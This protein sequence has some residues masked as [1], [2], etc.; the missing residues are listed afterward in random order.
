MSALRF[1]VVMFGA[2]D[3]YEVPL[4]LDE[5]GQLN[6]LITDFYTPDWLTRVL[7]SRHHPRLSSRKT[8]SVWPI[9]LLSK[10]VRSGKLGRLVVNDLFGFIGG[11]ITYLGPNRAIV[12]SY[13][14]EGFVAFYRLIGCKPNALIC[15]Q[16]H[17][18]PWFINRII[19]DDAEAF[20]RIRRVAFLKDIEDSYSRTEINAYVDALNA[21]DSILCASSVTARS[22]VHPRAQSNPCVVIPYGSRHAGYPLNASRHW[23][24]RDK[25]KILTVS[26]VMQ[27]KGLHWAFE[28]M[29]RLAP[30]LQEHFE[31]IVVSFRIDDR[32]ADLA[33]TNVR[34]L[35]KLPDGELA[36]LMGSADLFVMPS[37][38]EGFGLV[39]IEVLSLGTPIVYTANTGVDDLCLNGVHGFRVDISS[40]DGLMNLFMSLCATP[41]QLG[42]M[43]EKCR[44]LAKTVTW[45]R[46][47]ERVRSAVTAVAASM[48]CRP[49][50]QQ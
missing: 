41:T 40:L 33:P 38:V 50:S 39:Y 10:L 1:N 8:V 23:R 25:V 11:L 26:Q 43:R 16:V 9:A 21:C 3:F 22:T 17:P 48:P 46:F 32:I 24:A 5:S 20:A 42:D 27:R 6:R 14:I 37:I 28:A 7:K 35:P 4:A 13:Y 47:R 19:A 45:E 12:Y 15:F 34:F 36:D 29:S 49:K 31:W 30:E 44:A 2:R 18:T